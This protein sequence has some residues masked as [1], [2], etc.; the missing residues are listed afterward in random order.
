MAHDGVRLLLQ[1]HLDALAQ[2]VH[3]RD[4]A[5][6]VRRV[7]QR[8]RLG[9]GL[10][11]ILIGR[12]LVVEAAHQAAAGAGDLGGIQAE[13]LRLCHFDGHGLEIL[14]KFPAAEGAAADAQTADHLGLVAHADL[15]QLY[16]GA[17]DGGQ[18]LYQ[19]TE[20]HPSVRREK[21]EDLAA[22]KGIFRGNELHFQPQ[23][24]DLLLADLQSTF[25]TLAVFRVDA[26][27]LRRGD[28]DHRAQRRDDFVRLHLVVA[29]D[30][31][32]E[33]RPAGGV[34]DHLVPGADREVP[35]GEEIGFCAGAELDVADRYRRFFRVS[36]FVWC[37]SL[38]G[39]QHFIG[40]HSYSFIVKESKARRRCVPARRLRRAGAARF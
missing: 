4:R 38:F 22:V 27:V 7:H 33:F 8:F 39:L 25:F 14:Q 29:V 3:I 34:D 26:L 9:R 12:L 13:I 20:V 32:A 30:A 2:Q 31:A 35:G 24:R 40:F 36:G 28:T 18:R 37:F 21:E 5:A 16:A 17:Q 1:P 11:Q 23:L 15:A 6:A 10:E 19:L